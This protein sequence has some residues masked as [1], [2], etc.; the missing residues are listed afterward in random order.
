[1]SFPN[2]LS[3]LESPAFRKFIVCRFFLIMGLRMVSTVVGYKLFQLT[4]SSFAIGLVGLSEF[5]PAFCLSL[6]AGH[7]IDQSDKRTLLLRGILLYAVCV[8]ALVVLTNSGT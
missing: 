2:S 3:P 4:Q 1:M 8:L 5:V 6:Y 7:R